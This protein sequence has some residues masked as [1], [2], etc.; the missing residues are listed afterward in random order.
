MTT[1]TLDVPN[2]RKRLA[3]LAA[4]GVYFGTSS[5]KYPGWLD[6]VYTRDRYIWRG[7]FAESR[8]ERLCLAEYAE[9]FPAVCVDA[10]YYTFP[11]ESS[12][13]AVSE[14]VPDTFRFAFK[15]T[16]D[17]TLKRFPVLARFGPRA[18][19]PN[20]NFLN[21]DLFA[22]RFIEPCRCLG[23]KAGLMMFEFSRFHPGEFE[24]GR[25]FIE[26]LEAFLDRLP[27]G[28]RYGV[29]IRN[30]T[31]LQ[32]EYFEVL[33]RHGVAHVFNS[34]EGM[35]PVAEQ[36]ESAG[37]AL[38]NQFGAARFLLRPGRDYKEAVKRFSPYARLQDPYP[39][40]VAAG[41]RLLRTALD[42]PKRRPTFIFV[43]NRFEGNA[44]RSIRRMLDALE[45]ESP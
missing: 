45:P 4:S 16:G 2:L 26:A 42:N 20:P 33:A 37:A 7:R 30:S 39:E 36:I 19:Q 32:P 1:D 22:E 35:P 12:L 10:A 29:E 38:E 28:F 5:W 6:S 13:I 27:D 40:G 44:P 34:W 21:A 24:R 11:R 23:A 31:F 41:A 3:Q 18:G 15:V 9:T 17:I 8:F 25:D 43:N 14:Q